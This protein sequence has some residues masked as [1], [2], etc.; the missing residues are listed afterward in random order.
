MST[1]LNVLYE[2]NHLLVV[3]KPAGLLTQPSGTDQDSLEAQAKA[4]IKETYQKPGLVFLESVHRLDKPVSGI[5]VFGRTSKA[6]SRLNASIR[7]K[8]TQKYYYA[9]IQ[10]KVPSSTGSSEGR[11]EHY[12]IHDEFRAQIADRKNPEAKLA[13]LYYRVI[14]Q[15]EHVSLLEIELDTGRYHQIR[16]QLSTIGCPIVGDV[17]YGSQLPFVGE[18]IA[19]HHFK[20]RIPHPVKTDVMLFEAPLPPSFEIYT[21]AT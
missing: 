11:L 1:K 18:G 16:L 8:K 12:M 20:L 3:N 17:K 4:W 6:L 21:Q 19:L 2:D 7:D 13:R 5:V 15:T 9:L 10:G 14:Q